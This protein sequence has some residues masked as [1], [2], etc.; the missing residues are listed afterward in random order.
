MQIVAAVLLACLGV[1]LAFHYYWFEGLDFWFAETLR[2]NEF[3]HL[4]HFLGDERFSIIAFL[5]SIAIVLHK[6]L[7]DRLVGF[8]VFNYAF[9]LVVNRVLK[10]LVERPRPE[11]VDQLTSFS[12]PSGHT[13]GSLTFA[14]VTIYL[15]KKIVNRYNDSVTILLIGSA[16][17]CG[18]S[19]IADERHFFSDVLVG[20]ILSYVIYFFVKKWYEKGRAT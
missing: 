12:M 2:G 20:W 13:M 9:M 16:I 7:G 17:L 3:L 4:F 6:K 8:V 5:A 1:I 10:H 19:R 14:L 11:I 15:W 18:L